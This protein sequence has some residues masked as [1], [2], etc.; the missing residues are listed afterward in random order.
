MANGERSIKEPMAIDPKSI[1]Q[2]LTSYKKPE[3]IIGENGLPKQ[4]TKAVLERA[5]EAEIRHTWAMRN[6]IR[7]ANT[8]ATHATEK[9]VRR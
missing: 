4:L 8:R 3:D 2:L 7:Q 5:L 1:D 9:A 6:T